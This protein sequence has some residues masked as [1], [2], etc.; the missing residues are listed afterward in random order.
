MAGPATESEN[1]ASLWKPLL[2]NI[3]REHPA[4]G[5]ALAE[6][7]ARYALKVMAYKDEYEV[8]R[9]YTDG[10]F[11]R[12]VAEEFEGEGFNAPNDAVVH[13]RDHSIWFT[14]PGYGGLMNYEG[15]RENTGSVQPLQKVASGG[16]LSRIALALKTCTAVGQKAGG[17]NSAVMR[18]LVFDEVDAGVGGGATFA[19]LVVLPA[20][21]FPVTVAALL[22]SI[23]PLIDMART[24]LNVNGA[25]TAGV[26]ARKSRAVSAWVER[27]GNLRVG[28]RREST[29]SP[30]DGGA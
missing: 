13:P 4:L 12:Q 3:A 6:A 7:V 30:V 1:P 2:D 29:P 25:M 9:L 17:G 22:I 24:A 5:G 26:I 16:E 27:I 28:V 20:M 19:A 18:T 10:S 8:A 23:E 11:E 21:G 15:R 14:D